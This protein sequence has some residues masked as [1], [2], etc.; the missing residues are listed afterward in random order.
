MNLKHDNSRLNTIIVVLIIVISQF[1]YSCK[2]NS[3]PRKIS[4]EEKDSIGNRSVDTTFIHDTLYLELPVPFPVLRDTIIYRDVVV[5]PVVDT[6]A[7]LGIYN[8]K[9]VKTDTLKL[10]Y[11]YI[12]I[13][14]TIS[15]NTVVSRK[16]FS[17]MKLPAKE[18]IQTIKVLF[19]H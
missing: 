3:S 6:L 15:G 18:N 7:I 4:S 14:D 9:K 13:I 16:Y 10:E 11:G 12:T 19:L 8:T 17:K 1:F 2:N 5:N